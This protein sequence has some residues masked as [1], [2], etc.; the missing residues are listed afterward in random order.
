MPELRRDYGYPAVWLLMILIAAA[1]LD[2]FSW[3]NSRR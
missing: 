2:A 1:L 3:R